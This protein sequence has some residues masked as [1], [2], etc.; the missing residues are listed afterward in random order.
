MQSRG[1]PSTGCNGVVGHLLGSIS[2]ASLQEG[3]LKLSLVD[4]R[5]GLLQNSSV[6]NVRHV[7]GLTDHGNLELVLDHAGDLDGLLQSI[8]VLV[9]KLEECDV[10]RDLFRDRIGRRLGVGLPKVRQGG[11]QLRGELDLVDVVLLESLIDAEGE[12]GPD[13]AFGVDGGDKEDRLGGLDVVDVVAVGEVAAGKV[14][15]ESALAIDL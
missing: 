13:D 2:H 9:L 15:E 12:T 8:K 11:V 1:S 3:S 6:R 4:G 14:V 5:L 7:V 10:V